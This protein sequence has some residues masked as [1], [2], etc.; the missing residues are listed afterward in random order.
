VAAL[1]AATARIHQADM[2][3]RRRQPRHQCAA[4]EAAKRRSFWTVEPGPIETVFVDVGGTLWPNTWPLTPAIREGR[5]RALDLALVVPGAGVPVLAAI[6]ESIDEGLAASNDESVE[7]VIE[8]VLASHKL[9]ND[10]S[11]VRR[12]RQALSVNLDELVPPFAHAGE[13]LQGIKQLGSR[14]VILSNTT[15]RDA[16]MYAR[17]FRTL[18]WSRWIDDCITSTDVGAAKP[19][20]RIFAAA[21]N[22]AAST[23]DRCVMIGDSE[24]A[25][26]APARRLGM[27]AILV[28]IEDPPPLS[29]SANCCA[30]TLSEVLDVLREWQTPPTR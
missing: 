6:V 11:L 16:E 1:Q 13:L 14:C 27:R 23:A 18:D 8:R 5:A 15:F 25:D 30:T 9:S 28:A 26:I 10:A 22:S 29:T 21:L 24:R 7:A 19:D 12:V 2:Y 20:N 17:D 3:V 4:A